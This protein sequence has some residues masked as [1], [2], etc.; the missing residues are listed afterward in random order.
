MEKIY[1]EEQGVPESFSA[2]LQ[3]LKTRLDESREK[4]KAGVV[5]PTAF[6]A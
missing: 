4:Y 3:I 5:S 2:Y 1:A 6:T